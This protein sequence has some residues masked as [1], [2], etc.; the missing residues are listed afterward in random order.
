[1]S[2]LSAYIAFNKATNGETDIKHEKEMS[3]K[4]MAWYIEDETNKK[5]QSGGYKK[6]DDC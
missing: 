2:K 5:L 3:R 4:M 1:M 6:R